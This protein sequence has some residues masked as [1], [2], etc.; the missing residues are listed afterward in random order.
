MPAALIYSA[1]TSLD[2]YV[3]DESGSFDW[4][5]PDEQVHAFVNDQEREVG[6][7]LYGR[8]LYDVMKVWQTMPDGP[9]EHPVTRDYAAI[10][11]AADKVVYSRTLAAVDTPRTTLA[12]ELDAGTVREVKAAATRDLSI[13]G[14]TLAGDALRAGVV[15]EIRQFLCP[16]VVG[17][18]RYFLPRGL[19]V[20][21]ELCDE[22]RFDAGTVYVR[23]RVRAASD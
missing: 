13:G 5:A 10:W 14:P 12:R 2:G 17:G 11:R 18:G 4:A 21:L 1:I 20:N 8:R 3:V 7:Y 23:Y 9:D 16:V 15:D 19:R 22:R 6:T